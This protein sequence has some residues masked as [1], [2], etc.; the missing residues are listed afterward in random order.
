MRNLIVDPQL[1]LL[2]DY[3]LALL[4]LWAAAA[5]ARDWYGLL[6]TLRDQIGVPHKL[7]RMLARVIPWVEAFVGLGLLVDPVR[8]AAAWSALVLLGV[9]SAVLIFALTMGK[10]NLKCNCFGEGDAAHETGWL[11]ARNLCLLA[12]AML[13]AFSTRTPPPPLID[14]A[15]AIMMVVGLFTVVSL[16]AGLRRIATY[17]GEILDRD[18]IVFGGA[19]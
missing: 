17:R 9:F 18:A 11:V 7:A 5:K 15:V 19:E 16:A 3:G 12:V 8:D 2:A 10:R 4:F 1:V 14:R 13:C 6:R